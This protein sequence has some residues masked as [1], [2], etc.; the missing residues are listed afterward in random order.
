MNLVI[1]FWKIIDGGEFS[2]LNEVLSEK[3][4]VC[5]K[6]TSERFDGI[7]QYIDFNNNYPGKWNASI[8][9]LYEIN[10]GVIS[11]VKVFNAEGDSFYVVSVFKIT[12]GLITEISEY[13][14]ENGQIPQWRV[15][16]K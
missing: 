7:D 6:N 5:L 2:F 14:G 9:C 1:R 8:E 3:V 16:E 10:D 11:M 12:A 15:E 13:W 4:K